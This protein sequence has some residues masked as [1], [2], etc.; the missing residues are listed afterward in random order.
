M[1]RR[2]PRSTLFPYT[3]LFRSLPD[4][5]HPYAAL[6][7]NPSNEWA[8]QGE[9]VGAGLVRGALRYE[10]SVDLRLDGEYIHFTRDS[11]SV[12]AVPGRRAQWTLTG[13]L[14][15]K[16]SHGFFF[17]D[18]RVERISTDAGVLTR[19]RLG[20]SLQTDEVRLLPYVRTEHGG[21][22]NGEFVGLATFVLP[23]A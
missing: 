16:T 14:R 3:T 8:I 20:A 6:V 21:A 7:G 5:T 13:F 4:R 17:F 15:P 18:G 23:Q 19:T 12:L 10:P 1:I 2:P 22:T 9:V 11:A